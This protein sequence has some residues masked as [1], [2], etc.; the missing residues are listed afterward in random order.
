MGP[1]QVSSISCWDICHAPGITRQRI[2]SLKRTER[3][4]DDDGADEGDCCSWLDC[5]TSWPALRRE[6]PAAEAQLESK[7]AEVAMVVDADELEESSQHRPTLSLSVRRRLLHVKD[8]M[9]SVV[10]FANDDDLLSC[11]QHLEVT[12]APSLSHGGCCATVG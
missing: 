5:W 8:K 10:C 9:P 11:P 4:D 12:A 3:K 7:P 1:C 2:L 6:I